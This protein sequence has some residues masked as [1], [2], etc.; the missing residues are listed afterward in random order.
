MVEVLIA[1]MFGSDRSR[2][3][4]YQRAVVVDGRGAK[5]TRK[6]TLRSEWRSALKK[7]LTEPALLEM[8][9]FVRRLS[10]NATSMIGLC[11]EAKSPPDALGRSAGVKSLPFQRVVLASRPRFLCEDRT[12]LP[13]AGAA[14][15]AAQKI[16]FVL[17]CQSQN[18]STGVSG[19]CALVPSRVNGKTWQA[20]R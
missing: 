1:E 20:S 4:D 3:T 19:D 14:C 12:R 15:P 16:E 7:S 9:G 10:G 18:L 8:S 6:T 13:F 11:Q 5:E 17:S 2:P